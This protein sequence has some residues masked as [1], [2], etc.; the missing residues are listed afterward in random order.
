MQDDKVLAMIGL[1]RRAGQADTGAIMATK[2]I[3]KGKS[4]LIIVAGDGAD[5]VKK[6]F[7]NSCTYYEI[8]YLEIANKELL[9]KCTGKEN[10]AVVSIN[11]SNFARGIMSKL[12]TQK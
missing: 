8:P 12:E 2:A 10:I 7:T 11:D 1:A 6:K 3:Q 9:S 4:E 5:N